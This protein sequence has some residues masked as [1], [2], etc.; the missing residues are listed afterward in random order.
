M[1]SWTSQLAAPQ[2]RFRMTL[3][4][5]SLLAMLSLVS[6]C[7]GSGPAAS[8]AATAAQAADAPSAQDSAADMAQAQATQVREDAA[9]RLPPP[10]SPPNIAPLYRA[11]FLPNVV[12]YPQGTN[13]VVE[14]NGVPQHGSPYFP[15]GTPGHLPY[16]GNN[17][18]F[19][20]NGN[21]ISLGYRYRFVIPACPTYTERPTPTPLGPI[22]VSIEG[23]P[24]YNQYA[25]GGALLGPDE[26]DSFDQY[27]GHAD[28]MN[29][30]HHH[31]EPWWLTIAWDGLRLGQSALLGYLLDGHPVYG[32]MD[33][34][35]LVQWWQLDASHGH[36]HITAEYPQGIYHYHISNQPPYINGN[37]FRARPGYALVMP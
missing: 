5:A 30:Y 21:V 18:R 28:P 20:N 4:E 10:C 37:G 29:K 25:G 22:G 15:P 6:A 36:S 8:P 14:S 2:S 33:N 16:T 34:G 24:F 27:N 31:K 13:M 7:G 23:V 19:F 35:R 11:K 26:L 12:V 32:P 9:A 3:C 17:P 1:R